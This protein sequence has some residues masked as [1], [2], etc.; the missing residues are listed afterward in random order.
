M[1][2]KVS[3]SEKEFILEIQTLVCMA[4]RSLIWGTWLGIL[5]HLGAGWSAWVGS[6]PL[7]CAIRSVS[8]AA[9]LVGG[10]G[11]TG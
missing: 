11:A 3:F 8:G 2:S 9:E 10:S 5:K 6:L 1:G 4:E 7:G